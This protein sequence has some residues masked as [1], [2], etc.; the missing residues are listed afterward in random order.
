MRR[1]NI[2]ICGNRTD[3]KY[4]PQ[5]LSL[6][7]LIKLLA[8][9]KKVNIT[10]EEY[11]KL[12]KEKQADIKDIG[13]YVAG[14]LE[15]NERK[16]DNVI[17][18]SLITLDIDNN[19]TWEE[20]HNIENK[21]FIEGI[22]LIVH[23]TFKSSE[24]SP[25]VRL[26]V[27]LSRDCDKVEYEF[28]ARY[29]ANLL[30]GIN[31]FDSTTFQA[32]RMMYWPAVMKN[33]EYYFYVEKG[34]PL[35]V[36]KVLKDNPE[37]RD[38]STWIYQDKEKEDKAKQKETTGKVVRGDSKNGVVGAFCKVFSL[39]EAIEK[40]L[41]D[42]YK[43]GTIKGRYTYLLGSAA[44]GL[45]IYKDTDTCYC[46]DDTDPANVGT[47]LNAF[48]LVRIHK[49]GELDKGHDKEEVT[50]LPSYK[51]MVEHAKRYKEV[52]TILDKE[53]EDELFEG[54]EDNLFDEEVES[55]EDKSWLKRLKTYKTKSGSRIAE[56]SGNFDL[57]FEN[58]S[59]LKGLVG[60]DE[61][62]GFITFK[63]K[64]Y[65]QSR[66]GTW[67]DSDMS[68]LVAH[69]DKVYQIVNRTM[70]NEALTRY[71]ENNSFNPIKDFIES[72][73]WDG[74]KRVE[75]LFIDYNGAEDN[76]YTRAITRKI[77]EAAVARIYHPGCKWD[78]MPILV[79]DQGC[80]KSYIL[81]LLTGGLFNG[82]KW[83]QDAVPDFKS[84]SAYEA[85]DGKWI[86][87]IGEL[88][89]FNYSDMETVKLFLSKSEDVYRKAYAKYPGFYPRTCIFVGTSNADNFLRDATGERR[90]FPITCS[91]SRIKKSLIKD[92]TIDEV[93]Q[94]W[95]EA[96]EIYKSDKEPLTYFPKEINEYVEEARKYYANEDP[97]ESDVEEFLSL[98]LPLE[99]FD[100]DIKERRVYLQTLK[101]K[102]EKSP[103]SF[104]GKFEDFDDL[105]ELGIEEKKMVRDK[106]CPKE[107]LC[108]L[109]EVEPGNIKKTDF[110]DMARIL[111]KLG[112]RKEHLRGS[113]KIYG[114]Q[115][116]W[117]RSM[118]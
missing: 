17:S 36:D 60:I 76:L 63:R 5:I 67:T 27:P 92:F 77:L 99:Y 8:S 59:K 79:G 91:S 38:S 54:I 29:T 20:I 115:F 9:P 101:E 103:K 94:V 107:I 16:K 2:E 85:V 19:L 61:T 31:I 12:D 104:H 30:T 52:R 6:N 116:F 72:A 109:F 83:F 14:V 100:L 102:G 46:E 95:A 23:S 68:F 78:Y 47:S 21:A 106:V 28:L 15:N 84:K 108:E 114:R 97:R 50:S 34:E 33:E 118:E 32:N 41:S 3:K 53:S 56:I 18:R 81:Y 65:W 45:R 88:A 49:Y 35:D 98:E 112:R 75:T 39:E 111:K 4:A 10:R 105:E 87:E 26:I 117:K 89:V 80:G 24:E 74:K 7:E 11:L 40:F 57:I 71:A 93:K 73:K 1:F 66:M 22:E 51:K 58:D 69:F 62:N 64:P 110:Y 96:L 37:F 43:K 48:D 86:V 82:G 25:R 55:D 42:I 13:G 70:I 44:N 90:F 113:D